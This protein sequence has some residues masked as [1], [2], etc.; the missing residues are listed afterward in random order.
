M[1]LE[2]PNNENQRQGAQLHGGDW[3]LNGQWVLAEKRLIHGS[4]RKV[5]SLSYPRGSGGDLTSEHDFVNKQ[6]NNE[7]RGE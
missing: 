6:Y 3:R 2:G 1:Y 7:T 4:T 5:D